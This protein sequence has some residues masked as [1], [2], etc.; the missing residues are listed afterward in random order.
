MNL[1]E[2]EDCLKF[3]V[4]I[5]LVYKSMNYRFNIDFKSHVI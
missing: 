4:F 1:I 3:I 2:I 5:Q